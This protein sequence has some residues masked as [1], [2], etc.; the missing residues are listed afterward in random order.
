MELLVPAISDIVFQYSWTIKNYNKTIT[1]NSFID[2]PNFELNVNGIRS[3]WN[4][5]IR[6]W[7][8]PEGKRLK[9]PIVLCLNMLNCKVKAVEQAKIRFQ[10]GIYNAEKNKWEYFSIRRTILELKST[11]DITSLGYRELSVME[12]HLKNETVKLM[13]KIQIQITE[14]DD[15]HNLTQDALRLTR[16]LKDADTKFV[17]S[18]KGQDEIP[19]HEN[20]K[21]G[22][23][24]LPTNIGKSKDSSQRSKDHNDN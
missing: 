8:G 22:S 13:V 24:D 10:F 12:R 6:F 3:S 14:Y 16:H 19:G 9:N 1:K 4:L 5:S 20:V 11:A 7:K 2:S 21:A 17:C 23:S 18:G 15:K